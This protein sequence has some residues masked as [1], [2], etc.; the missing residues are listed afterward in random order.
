MV[1]QIPVTDICRHQ[2]A[3][4]KNSKYFYITCNAWFQK[5]FTTDVDISQ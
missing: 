5:L 3:K 2:N 1:S 4:S